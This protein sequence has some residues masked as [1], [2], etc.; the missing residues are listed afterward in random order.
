MSLSYACHYTKQNVPAL[1]LQVHCTRISRDVTS[2]SWRLPFIFKKYKRYSLRLCTHSGPTLP[3]RFN[4]SYIC[5]SVEACEGNDKNSEN[6]NL[7]AVEYFRLNQHETG[8]KIKGYGKR[9]WFE[10][11][12]CQ[13]CNVLLRNLT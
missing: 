11:R 6:L 3:A 4:H 2:N 8:I 7:Y 1:S 9:K 12:K 5:R 13:H 10:Y